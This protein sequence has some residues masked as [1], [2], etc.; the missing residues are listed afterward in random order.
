MLLPK[1][2]CLASVLVLVLGLQTAVAQSGRGS[3]GS[4]TGTSSPADRPGPRDIFLTGN[5]VT[6]DGVPP[7]ERV[8]I[9]RVCSNKIVRLGYTDAKGF[10]SVQLM[11]T[12]PVLQ[13]VSSSAMDAYAGRGVAPPTTTDVGIQPA[14]L[15]VGLGDG[16]TTMAGCELRGRLA[17]FQSTSV[18]IVVTGDLQ[19]LNLGTIVLLKGQE[20]GSTVS[21][22]S[23]NAPKEARKAYEKASAHLQKHKL[24]EAQAELERAVKLYPQYA[25][26]WTSL[27]GLHQQQNRLDL[28]RGAFSQAQAADDKFVP[29]YVGLAAVAVRQ[30]QWAEAEQF[31]ARATQL[32]GVDFPVA[33]FYNAV[34]NFELGQLAPAEKSA[35]MAERLDG[36]HS[37]PQVLLLQGAILAEKRDYAGAAEEL[38]LYLKFAPAAAN[39]EKVRGQVVELEK[40]AASTD[41]TAAPTA[42]PSLPAAAPAAPEVRLT[43][44]N[45]RDEIASAAGNP[46]PPVMAL[47]EDWAP[48][49]VDDVVPPV[50]PDVPC[51]VHEVLR[52]ASMRVKELMDN[53]QQFSATERIEHESVDKQGNSHR[54][55]SVTFK[56]VA[57]IRVV[58]PGQLD[59]QEYRSGS[60]STQSF[61]AGLATRG[62][63]TH[64]LMFLPSMIDDLTVTCE[65]LGSVQGKPAWQL[66]FVQRA[67]RPPRFREYHTQKG[68]F[69]VAIKGRAWIAADNYQV[70]RMETD[71]AKPIEEIALRKDHVIID[72]RPV[73]FRTRN[74][75]LWLP[76]TTDLYLDLNG[77]RSHRRHSLSDFELFWVD[78]A[79]KTQP[80]T[81]SGPP[82]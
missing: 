43:A 37:M 82:Q 45:N 57:Q 75:Q 4:A 79:G 16:L 19:T 24:P 35:R 20:Q 63:A 30:S 6:G 53:L 41:Q 77:Q 74:I 1:T 27:G 33:F 65:G 71:L 62:M 28:A 9:E 67:D 80:P 38:K 3:G 17:G 18:M 72:Y 7:P 76:E 58:G 59:T 55:E 34:A 68:Y 13:D 48:P 14:G 44:L 52:A 60:S 32:D 36:R 15:P 8:A 40:L 12:N 54:S 26:A 29:A 64:A 49:D 42:V 46:S 25:A 78:V 11:E 5:V 73:E 56:Y 50:R 47:R 22:T 81:D 2:H 23:V 70:M 31:S 39:L 66:H 61:P 21:A 69:R 10:F 51:A